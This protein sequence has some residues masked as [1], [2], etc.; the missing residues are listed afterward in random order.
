[1]GRI[2]T[3]ILV[4]ILLMGVGASRSAHAGD[5]GLGLVLG[6]PSGISAQFG[7]SDS[8]KLNAALG[9]DTFDDGVL[10][11][12]VD[13]IRHLAVLLD[14]A[15][16]SLPVYVGLGGFL[17]E[18]GRIDLGARVPFGLQLDFKQAPLHLFLEVAFKLRIIEDIDT[19]LDAALGF[20]YF[21]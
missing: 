21:F 8:D 12:H 18:R 3:L 5:F 16:V 11:V 2:K 1:M 20:R 17:V 10:Y 13:Y 4:M 9:L 15:D 7:L 19:D 6:E 14:G